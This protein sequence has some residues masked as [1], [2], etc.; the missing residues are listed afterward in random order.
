MMEGLRSWLL[1]VISVSL[2]C[3]LADALM[4]RGPVRRVGKLVCGLVLLAALLSPIA[5]LDAAG[6][7]RWLEDYFASVDGRAAELREELNGQMK[8]II[9]RECA[10][11]I[12][13]KA[14]E[15]GLTCSARVECR[16]GEEGLY[17]PVYA[18]ITGE[19]SE[20]EKQQLGRYIA[21]DLGVPE[22]EQRYMDKEEMP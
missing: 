11:Y 9:E 15:L 20:R 13:D 18:E 7:Q 3:A 8:V 10:A 5:Q 1:A 16:A 4:P 2:L 19:L 12:V 21:E 14:A 6:G 22:T 17:L